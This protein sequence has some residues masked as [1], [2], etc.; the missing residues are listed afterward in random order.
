MGSERD[1]IRFQAEPMANL[2]VR[3]HVVADKSKNLHD[4]MLGHTDHIGAC[5]GQSTM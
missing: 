4:D 5:K 3:R 1:S 2:V